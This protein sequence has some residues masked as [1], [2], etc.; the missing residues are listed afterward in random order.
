MAKILLIEDD[1]EF[2]DTLQL[3]LKADKHTVDC[4]STVA[5]AQYRLEFYYFDLVILDLGLPDGSGMVVLN[6]YRNS[7]G[8]VPF[9]I[10]TG[11]QELEDKLK[12]FDQGADDYVTKPCNAKELAARIKAVL[13][14]P[15][16]LVAASLKVGDIELR[17]D[18][19]LVSAGG[20]QLRLQGK[21]LLLLEFLMRHK[22]QAF[23]PD[24]ILERLWSSESEVSTQVVKVY[25]NKLRERLGDSGKVIHTV[26]GRGYMM[27]DLPNRLS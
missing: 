20:N 10:L 16:E 6:Q 15:K 24:A 7:G 17:P 3:W 13:R 22:D 21:E 11:K 26:R 27:S 25:I 8:K 9:I 2:A 12:G 4:V 23:S 1:R 14:R 18:S 19:G 5:D